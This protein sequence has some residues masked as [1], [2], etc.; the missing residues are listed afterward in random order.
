MKGETVE[1]VEEPSHTVTFELYF[2]NTHVYLQTQLVV[3]NGQQYQIVTPA[4]AAIE[5]RKQDR[6]KKLSFVH[7]LPRV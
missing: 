5:V 7:F 3:I 6:Q 2:T 1:V 4:S